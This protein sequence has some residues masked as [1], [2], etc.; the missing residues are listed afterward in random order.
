MKKRI[1]ASEEISEI[2]EA[3]AYLHDDSRY[4]INNTFGIA[5][6]IAN[7]IKNLGM[8]QKEISE[9]LGKNE[10]E[11]SKWLSGTHNFT[12]RS[13]SKIEAALPI[14]IINPA[15]LQDEEKKTSSNSLIEAGISIPTVISFE[16]LEYLDYY[17]DKSSGCQSK[18]FSITKTSNKETTV[19]T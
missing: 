7:T 5:K 9:K 15:I 18:E 4:F 13:I 17:F 16:Q 10:A 8:T 3:I 11:I 19:L 6:Y 2:N 12:L 1:F 14:K